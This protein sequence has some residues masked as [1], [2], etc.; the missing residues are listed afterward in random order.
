MQI[1]KARVSMVLNKRRAHLLPW[2]SM[3]RLH[4]VTKRD[5][6]FFS[7]KTTSLCTRNMLEE[8]L[9]VHQVDSPTCKFN[10]Q[11]LLQQLRTLY[12]ESR[13]YS[14]HRGYEST[15]LS[16]SSFLI[17][18]SNASEYCY[19]RSTCVSITSAATTVVTV[20]AT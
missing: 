3:L 2:D 1:F 12:T 4:R 18:P 17:R 13:R 7:D 15:T 5:S 19:H 8:L 9:L 20:D 16:C 6:P 10:F 11:C 14:M